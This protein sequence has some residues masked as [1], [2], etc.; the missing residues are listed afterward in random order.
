LGVASVDSTA[1]R[2]NQVKSRALVKTTASCIQ[3]MDQNT[4]AARDDTV[5]TVIPMIMIRNKT[6]YMIPLSKKQCV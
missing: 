6:V 3:C 5:Y 4:E 2:K 1:K